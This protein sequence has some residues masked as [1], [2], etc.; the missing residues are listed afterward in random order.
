[1]GGIRFGGEV[2]RSVICVAVE[3]NFV[4]TEDIAHGKEVCNDKE[5]RVWS[6][7]CEKSDETG[8]CILEEGYEIYP[9]GPD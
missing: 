6:C 4:P 5:A 1:M 2:E 7:P 3:M 8:R 9:G